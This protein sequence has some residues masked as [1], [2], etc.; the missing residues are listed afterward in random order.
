V[1]TIVNLLSGDTAFLSA[2]AQTGTGSWVATNGTLQRTSKRSKTGLASLLITGTSNGGTTTVM[3]HNASTAPEVFPESRYRGL[4]WFHHEI[5]NRAITFGV[6]FY[7]KNRTALAYTADHYVTATQGFNEWTLAYITLDAPTDARYAALRID[8][9]SVNT[10]GLDRFLWLE[11]A[12]LVTYGNL[13]SSRFLNLFSRSVPDWMV[14]EDSQQTNPQFPMMRFVDLMGSQMDD[15]LDLISDFHYIPEVEG[16]PV[17]D[18]SSLVD[19]SNYGNTNSEMV[20]KPEWLPWLAQLVG[21]RNTAITL[22]SG[23]TWSTLEAYTTWASWEADINAAAATP[24]TISSLSRTSGTVTVTTSVAHGLEAGDV[25]TIAGTTITSS[26]AAD[27]P[28]NG[29]YEVLSASGTNLS[30]SQSYPILSAIQSGTTTVTVTV[31]RPHGF[32]VGNTV[33]LSNTAQS[34]FNGTF[35]ITAVSQVGDDGGNNTFTF[36]AGT[37]GTRVS[38]TGA[39]QPATNKNGTGG[40]ATPSDLKWSFIEASGGPG[41]DPSVTLAEF[42]R[43]GA[44]GVW[45]GTQE[46]MKRAARAAMS[47]RDVACTLTRIGGTVTARSVE[48][49]GLTNGSTV[50]IYGASDPTLNRSYTLTSTGDNTFTVPSGGSD[51]TDIRARVTNKAVTVT[52]GFWNGQITTVTVGASNLYTITFSKPLPAVAVSGTVVISGSGATA[53]NKT[54]TPTGAITVSADRLTISFTSNQ[55]TSAQSSSGGKA[56]IAIDS[57]TFVIG[58]TR[59][60]SPSDQTIIDF[61][62]LAKPAGAIITH[63]Y[64]S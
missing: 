60:Q 17:G 9:A 33:T 31:G 15:V 13:T 27:V 28:F 24:L 57:L 10:S 26:V 16:G 64:T 30:Y 56:K 59:A 34:A 6:Q 22:P 62:E 44:N 12:G 18:T 20:S 50:T 41:F 48:P 54:H 11:D 46:G 49:H 32:V 43:S 42:I 29:Y 37:S 53:V 61:V 47:G 39:V 21:V 3:S 51:V 19:P 2:Y 7:D 4:V 8:F 1:S 63:E 35:T 5:V 25:V 45:A 55:A 52:G 40:T 23:S 36:T 58:T 38:Y 14:I